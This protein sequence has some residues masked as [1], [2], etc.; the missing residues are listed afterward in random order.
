MAGTSPTSS[1][2]WPSASR[3]RWPCATQGSPRRGRRSTAAPTASR[4]RCSPPASPSRTS[5]PSTSTT[6]PST[7]S[8]RS[9][10]SRPGMAI[11][12]T[13]Y[14]YAADELVYLWDNA[15]V[16]AVVFHGTFAERIAEHAAPAAEASAPGCGS[17]TATGRA[18]SGRCRTRRRRRPPTDGH[19]AGP[20]GR[21]R[22]P[23]RP[24]L[25][26]RHDRHAEGRDV[27]PGRPLRRPRLGE[28]ASACRRAATSA[29]RSTGSPSRARATCP[30]RR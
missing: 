9:P 4:P 11:V 6:R 15:D 26:R 8:R 3:R 1:R 27:A 18:R 5:S 16:V 7:S 23:P 22:R 12:N 25:H 21:S 30:A 19:V 29:R 13:N 24:A 28:H 20:W 10:P 2:R 14:R 17:T